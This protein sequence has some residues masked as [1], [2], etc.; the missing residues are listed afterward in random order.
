MSSSIHETDETFPTGITKPIFTYSKFTNETGER[1][2]LRRRNLNFRVL[3]LLLKHH[4]LI[5]LYEQNLNYFH[6]R[7]CLLGCTYV[8]QNQRW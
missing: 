2:I 8:K 7:I 6:N 5:Y 3:W 1:T 4:Q